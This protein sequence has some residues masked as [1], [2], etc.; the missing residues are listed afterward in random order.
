MIVP[1]ATPTLQEGRGTV[2]KTP[3]INM[4]DRAG[5]VMAKVVDS[6]DAKMLQVAI[7][8]NVAKDTTV[9]TDEHASYNGL[10][11]IRNRTGRSCFFRI[12]HFYS[13]GNIP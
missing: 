8:E 12:R 13:S 9:C 3:V 7:K 5:Q 2:S 4:R 1:I 6:T 10:E 11:R